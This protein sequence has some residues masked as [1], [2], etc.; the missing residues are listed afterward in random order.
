MTESGIEGT[1][2]ISVLFLCSENSCRSQM[3]EGFL[4]HLAG[5]LARSAE[6]P[7]LLYATAE[8]GTQLVAFSLEAEQVRVIG[9]IGF[10]FSL[11]LAFCPPG[12][13]SYTITNIYFLYTQIALK[14]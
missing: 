4:R 9:N 2:K 12:K 1:R 10:P 8:K 6:E 14:T 7:S 3:A 11:P 13:A 5:N